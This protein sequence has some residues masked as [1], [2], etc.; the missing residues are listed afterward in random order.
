MRGKKGQILKFVSYYAE[1]PVCY[2]EVADITGIDTK[3][4]QN[5]LSLLHKQGFLRIAFSQRGRAF[6]ARTEKECID[7]RMQSK[8]G[9]EKEVLRAIGRK[10]MM[11]AAINA[12]VMQCRSC[13]EQTVSRMVAKG[14]LRRIK[15][16]C[17]VRV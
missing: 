10:T 8:L 6:F 16:G 3:T 12:R 11:F 9:K 2:K 13:L 14:S 4:V 7:E 1:R 5:Y 17:Y 15:R